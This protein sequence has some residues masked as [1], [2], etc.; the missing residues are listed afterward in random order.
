[1]AQMNFIGPQVQRLKF[2]S[3][4]ITWVWD[5]SGEGSSIINFLKV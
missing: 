2:T 1:M 5:G 4:A 3:A